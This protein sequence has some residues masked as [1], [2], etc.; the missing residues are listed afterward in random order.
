M[1]IVGNII[2]GS[3]DITFLDVQVSFDLSQSS[4][5]ISIVN[6]SQGPHLQNVTYW[7]TVYSPSKSPIHA[8]SFSNPDQVGIWT[9]FVLGDA[10]PMPWKQIEWSGPP[11]SFSI[12]AQ[13]S[14][15]NVYEV[16]KFATIVP[17]SGITS[18]TPNFFGVGNVSLEVNCNG[19]NIFFED[20]TNTSYNGITGTLI[21]SNLTVV[22][23]IDNTGVI[24]N[25]FSASNFPMLVPISY[26]G[27]NYQFTYTSTYSYS[28]GN[29]VFIIITYRQQ[30][31]FSVLCNVDLC[32]LVCEVA[33]MIESVRT[34]S[35]ANATDTNNKLIQITPLLLNALI[36]KMQP[37]C[38]V[39][40]PAIIDKIKE[41]GDFSCDTCSPNTAGITSQNSSIIGGYNFSINGTCGVSGNV[42]PNGN[43]ITFN[44]KGNTYQFVTSPT[45]PT[46]AFTVTPS[47]NGCNNLF[48]LN[49]NLTTL[50][51]DI[52]NTILTN[53]VLVTLFNSI[54]TQTGANI[55]WALNGECIFSS[56]NTFNYTYGLTNIPPSGTNALLTSISVNNVIKP[57]SFSFNQTNLT[58]LQ[59]YLNSLNIGTF[60]V[61]LISGVVTIQT[62]NNS[63]V[64]GNLVYSIGSTTYIANFSSTNTGWTP[65][66]PQFAVQQVINYL[67][68]LNESN[69]NLS[70]Q[71]L[72]PTII[73]NAQGQFVS[74]AIT[75]GP[76]ATTTPEQTLKDLLN[77][78]ITA[79]NQVIS[80]V[81]G[82]GAVN[83]QSLA[84]IFLKNTNL[85][86]NQSLL[87]GTKTVPAQGTTPATQVCAGITPSELLLYQLQNMDATTQVAFCA[88]VNACSVGQTCTPFNN[89][90]V[91]AVPH[92][93]T[94][95]NIVG[96]SGTFS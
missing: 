80:Y 21:F 68:A 7:F 81:L 94:C 35:C 17:P 48:S 24:P 50:S 64:L 83:C 51:T 66:D 8:G 23:P 16:D 27:T 4:P 6:L 11:Y 72:V 88:A 93:T 90:V 34:G 96:I 74:S 92:N 30:Q 69:V 54:V 44:L 20:N 87:Y 76:S 33:E 43:N 49:V 82:L 52:L 18:Q 61:T 91:Q 89:L 65:V 12:F 73:Q 77:A 57:L 32:P 84:A 47:L 29:G 36:G 60:T 9:N 28:Q 45:I 39:D 10:W 56:A 75:I 95:T 63:N 78:Y 13:D 15:G 22:Y 37:T 40:V 31:Q 53:P 71:Y 25:P 70:N 85:L 2:S 79:Q 58:G 62:N 38:G 5:S 26:N 42:T 3:N 67:C 59:T 86:S 14:A 46:T 41:I 55:K 19:A 1:P